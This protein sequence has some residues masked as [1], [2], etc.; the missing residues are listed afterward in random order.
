MTFVLCILPIFFI[1]VDYSFGPARILTL[2]RL[3]TVSKS[4]PLHK[5][6]RAL[7][8]TIQRSVPILVVLVFYT[9]I[10]CFL[11]S[12]VLYNCERGTFTVNHSYPDG[13]YLR[14]GVT[15]GEH[16]PTPY[17]SVASSAYWAW[18][19][20]TTTGYGDIYPTTTLGRF[21]AMVWMVC[22]IIVV[23]LP[24]SIISANFAEAL[25]EIDKESI[26]HLSRIYI[27]RGGQHSPTPER[28][29]ELVSLGSPKA[30]E[31]NRMI[32]PLHQGDSLNT[33]SNTHPTHGGQNSIDNNRDRIGRCVCPHC[34]QSF[35]LDE[36][37][38][39]NTLEEQSS[40]KI[41]RISSQISALVRELEM[42]RLKLMKS[43]ET[44]S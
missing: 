29:V 41:V 11:F 37:H 31:P 33:E 2:L 44:L 14:P 23:S 7:L 16:S 4:S 10:G 27:P 12:V 22:G 21:F 28:D 26:S 38:Y 17:V 6:T 43:V 19:T 15:R 25:K 1:S 8:I 18:V 5:S 42:E 30:E 9:L 24:V 3:L 34:N 39:I 35:R 32:S 40:S 36:G 20:V 13:A